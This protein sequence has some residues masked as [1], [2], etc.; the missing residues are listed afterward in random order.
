M[1]AYLLNRETWLDL[2]AWLMHGKLP[3]QTW[4]N[5]SPGAYLLDR[6]KYAD[7][8]LLPTGT[9]GHWAEA[10]A[11]AMKLQRS[12]GKRAGLDEGQAAGRAVC[13]QLYSANLR[14]VCAR[15]ASQPMDGWADLIVGLNQIDPATA[16]GWKASNALGILR[17]WDCQ[18]SEDVPPVCRPL[19]LSL[20]YAVQSFRLE[21]AQALLGRDDGWVERMG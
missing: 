19:H 16:R 14:A 18:C 1:S 15:Y 21:I 13:R 9:I 2:C 4:G 11:E 5:G 6:M 8:D 10:A 3:M 17:C 20:G 7:A 12:Y